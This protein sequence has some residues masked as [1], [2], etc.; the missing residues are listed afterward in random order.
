MSERDIPAASSDWRCFDQ[1]ADGEVRGVAE[2][3]VPVLLPRQTGLEVRLRDRLAPVPARLENRLDQ[4]LVAGRQ[5]ADQDRDAVALLGGEGSLGLPPVVGRPR[6]ADAGA[7][8]EPVARLRQRVGPPPPRRRRLAGAGASRRLPACR[9][10]S[11]CSVRPAVMVPS[12][13]ASSSRSRQPHYFTP[14]SR[15]APNPGGS[16]RPAGARGVSPPPTCAR[17]GGPH[18]TGAL[19]R[20]ISTSSR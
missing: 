10:A 8:L 20:P 19:W 14:L 7:A 1:R 11:A 13:E 17:I 4:L 2:A 15:S 16:R 9:R 3:V 5:A 12:F 18:L 6:R